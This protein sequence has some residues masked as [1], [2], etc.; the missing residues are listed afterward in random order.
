MSKRIKISIV[1]AESAAAFRKLSVSAKHAAEALR[2]ST[3]SMS[4]LKS[5][6][7]SRVKNWE[8]KHRFH[9]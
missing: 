7:K 8:P 9:S 4:K 2:N 5:P 3:I 6:Y 1:G